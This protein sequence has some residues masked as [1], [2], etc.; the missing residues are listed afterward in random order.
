MDSTPFSAA[1]TVGLATAVM[2][3]LRCLHPPGG[4]AA[5]SAVIGGEPVKQAGYAYA[6]DTVGLAA[7]ILVCVSVVIHRVGRNGYPNR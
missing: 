3:L 7:I 2:L 4:A 6:F 5:L 1:L